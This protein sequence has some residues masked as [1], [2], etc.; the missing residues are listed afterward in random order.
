MEKV[1][2]KICCICKKRYFGFGNNA[3]PLKNGR[4]CNKCNDLVI[5][6]RIKRAFKIYPQ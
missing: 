2:G 4:C 3:K 1:K 5:I 6:E